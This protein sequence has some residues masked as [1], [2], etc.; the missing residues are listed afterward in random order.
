MNWRL[1]A[2]S[3]V[4]RKHHL[5][6]EAGLGCWPG[7]M[8]WAE[9]SWQREEKWPSL[10]DLHP[11]SHVTPMSG[12]LIISPLASRIESVWVM[13]SEDREQE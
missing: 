7:A 11:R 9:T 5:G 4:R 6:R 1:E 3:E 2:D 13:A 8:G 10:P 12:E